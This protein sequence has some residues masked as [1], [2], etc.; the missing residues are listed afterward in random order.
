MVF[1]SQQAVFTLRD[2]AKASGI[3]LNT[4]RSFYQRD[5][6]RIVGGEAKRGRGIAADLTL[7]DILCIAVAGKLIE[8]G[9]RPKA[10]FEAAWHFAYASGEAGRDPGKVFDTGFTVMMFWPATE[11]VR[12]VGIDTTVA[13]ADLFFVPS[14]V[15]RANPIVIFLNDVD[16][17]VH[18][19][20]RGRIAQV[21]LDALGD[22][23]PDPF[24]LGTMSTALPIGSGGASDD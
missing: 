24:H 15:G 9:A 23:E 4:L 10:A 16:R 5:H 21:T 14:R 6:F 17:Q 13:F 11:D 12:I 3:A 19:A 7:L 2:A 8:C 22:D 18:L 20:L 1:D